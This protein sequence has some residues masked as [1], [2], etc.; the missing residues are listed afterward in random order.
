MKKYLEINSVKILEKPNYKAIASVIKNKKIN[1]KNIKNNQYFCNFMQK[2]SLKMYFLENK[3][4]FY[5]QICLQI[6]KIGDF[7]KKVKSVYKFGIE[8]E[9]SIE[10][11]ITALSITPYIYGENILINYIAGSGILNSLTYANVV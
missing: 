2:P 1:Y 10:S 7:S 9:E 11:L 6:I 5:K 8:V 3:E 4:K